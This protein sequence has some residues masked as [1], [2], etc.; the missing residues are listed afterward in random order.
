MIHEQ[1][2]IEAPSAG[3]TVKEQGLKH[4]QRRLQKGRPK[5]RELPQHRWI[6]GSCSA[7]GIGR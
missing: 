5:F 4:S 7:L 3:A 1:G 2:Q 6:N